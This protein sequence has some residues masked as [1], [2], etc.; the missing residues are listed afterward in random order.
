MLLP[1]LLSTY[2]L[3]TLSLS[4]GREI[5][6][7]IFCISSGSDG[8]VSLLVWCVLC[9]HIVNLHEIY[10]L[11]QNNNKITPTSSSSKPQHNTRPIQ[12]QS[13][14]PSPA[15]H[16]SPPITP[17][18]RAQSQEF[19]P[20]FEGDL[21]APDFFTQHPLPQPKPRP[22]TYAIYGRM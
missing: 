13:L 5:M 19:P 16:T 20:E 21:K 7:T 22:H 17:T 12:L 3:S 15:P 10:A 9:S 14:Y 6:F 8:G 18:T 2:E 1:L 4:V 11:S